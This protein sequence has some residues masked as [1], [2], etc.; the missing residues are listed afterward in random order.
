M[1]NK[2]ENQSG[3]IDNISEGNAVVSESTDPPADEELM[4]DTYHCQ[5]C[6]DIL[7]FSEDSLPESR[8]KVAQRIY[9]K[10]DATGLLYP[11][12]VRKVMWGPK[13]NQI[14][15]GFCSSLVDGEPFSGVNNDDYY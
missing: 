4:D 13:S 14:T 7:V 3:L 15:L 10:D 8:Y 1:H 2:P 5:P 6:K 11:A 12:F 9:A